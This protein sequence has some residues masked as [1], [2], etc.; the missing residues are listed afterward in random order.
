MGSEVCQ[1]P[2]TRLI[3]I[4]GFLLKRRPEVMRKA[5]EAAGGA[6]RES[7][8]CGD[9]QEKSVQASPFIHSLNEYFLAYHMPGT[10]LDTWIQQ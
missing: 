10:A 4:A 8:Q 2:N 6:E 1:R 3:F 7:E 5:E 9:R